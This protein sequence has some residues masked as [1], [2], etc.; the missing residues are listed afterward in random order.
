M[1]KN[2]IY[3]YNCK[4]E[5]NYTYDSLDRIGATKQD[6]RDTRCHRD[7]RGVTDTHEVY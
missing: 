7:T 1:S 5:C 3:I 2:Y 4:S 6:T